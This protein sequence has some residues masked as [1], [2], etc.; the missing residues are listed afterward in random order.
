MEIIGFISFVVV[1]VI[2]GFAA[3]DLYEAKHNTSI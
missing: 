3:A 1:L 2:M